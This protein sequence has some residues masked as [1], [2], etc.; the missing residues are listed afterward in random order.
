[1][2]MVAQARGQFTKNWERERSRR[3]V[4]PLGTT[5]STSSSRRRPLE[6]LFRPSPAGN[7]PWK[8]FQPLAL[9]VAIPWKGFHA[10]VRPS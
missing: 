9:T 4:K 8:G 7:A 10:S 3:W 6:L 2:P 1:M 5:F